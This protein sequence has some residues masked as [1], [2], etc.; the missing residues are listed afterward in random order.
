MI[1]GIKM[2]NS[3][4]T[5]LDE[6]LLQGK[7]SGDNTGVGYVGGNWKKQVTSSV[8]TFV[9]AGTRSNQDPKKKFNWRCYHYGKRGHIA[10]YYYRIYGRGRNKYTQSKMQWVRKESVVSH[11]VFAS[12]KATTWTGWYFDSGCSRHMTGDKSYLSNIETV[13]NDYV[14]FG[15]GEKGRIIGKRSLN[16][17][18]LPR[19]DDVLLVEGLTPNLISIS[20]LS[21]SGMKVVFSKEA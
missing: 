4:T 20:Q 12:L 14:T 11:V 13:R 15:G 9:A 16:V 21:D 10:P 8:R 19:L 2:M 3:S 18:R 1:R 7:R 5:I 17:E 6:I